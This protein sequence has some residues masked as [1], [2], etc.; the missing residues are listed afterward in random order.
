M[1]SLRI[2]LLITAPTGLLS[3]PAIAK[4]KNDDKEKKHKKPTE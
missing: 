3:L 4:D 1:P 2:L